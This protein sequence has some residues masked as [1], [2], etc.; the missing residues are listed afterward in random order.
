LPIDI[1]QGAPAPSSS[2]FKPR[3]DRDAEG[4]HDHAKDNQIL[5]DTD[6]GSPMGELMRQYWLPALKSS[7]LIADGDPVRFML[8]GEKLIAF[9]DTSGRIGVMDHRCPHRCASFFFG[10]NEGGGIVCVYHGW[11]FDVDGNCIDMPNLPPSQDF[12]HTV[13][14]KAYRAAERNGLV[15]I[16]MRASEAPALPEI[17]TALLPEDDVEYVFVLRECNWLQAMEG[18]L[19]TS[20]VGFLHFG[21]A[22]QKDFKSDELEQYVVA[23]RAP[24]YIVKDTDFGVMYGAYR[25]GSDGNTYWRIGHFMFPCWAMPPI[26]RIELNVR[27][28]AYVPLDNTHSLVVMMVKK[29]AP[30]NLRAE[31]AQRFAGATQNYNEF[32]N[33]T[34][35]HGRYRRVDNATN[36]Y[37]I[38]REVQRDQSYSGIDGVQLQDQALQESMGTIVDRT[39]EHLAPSDIMISHVR[40]RLIQAAKAYIKDGTLPAC[41]G[42][43]AVYS[44]GRAGHFEAPADKDW[45][46]AYRDKLAAS[47]VEAAMPM[48]AE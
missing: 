31:R 46:D 35:W 21:A 4:H 13:K 34:D 17:E 26:E 1:G 48:V 16:Y 42:R 2:N 43:P 38:D 3:F 44:G 12:K 36:D 47:P 25:P 24:E 20:H 8:L 19:D 45:L 30:A 41:Q 32:A 6:A 11:K 29:P 15:Y 39:F 33:S 18:E 40:R 5:T 7:Q 23:E 9:R 27:V 37:N 28:R 10:R 22:G 14:A